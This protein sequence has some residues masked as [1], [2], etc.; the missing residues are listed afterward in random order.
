MKTLDADKTAREIAWNIVR[1]I[2]R[3]FVGRRDPTDEDWVENH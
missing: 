3:D 1:D 2:R